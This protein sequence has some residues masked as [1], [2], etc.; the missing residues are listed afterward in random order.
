MK[1][2]GFIGVGVMGRSMVFN[3]MKKG[4]DLFIYTRT[5]SKVLDVIEKGAVWCETIEE[6]VKDVDAVITIVGF[7]NDVEEVYFG[8]EGILNN[9]KPDTFLIDMTTTSPKLSERIYK[10]GKNKGMRILDAPVT[11]GDVGA[12]NGTLSIMVGGDKEDYDACYPI[13]EVL[14]SN[15][16]YHG[17]AGRGQHAKMANQIAIAGCISGVCESLTYAKSAGL[18]LQKVLD[19]VST[20]SA[21]SWQMTNMAPRILDGDF[22]PGFFI[23]HFVK[24]MKIAFDEAKD[25]DMKLEMLSCVLNMYNELADKKGLGEKGTQ[26]LVKYYDLL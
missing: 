2:I 7:P 26:A 13:F 17:P 23:K 15:I 4:Y 6:C 12:K 20:G 5:K 10:E 3:L 8:P 24:D 18:D 11:G 16:V 25:R 19:T 21:G 22:E 14:G 9:A 1:K